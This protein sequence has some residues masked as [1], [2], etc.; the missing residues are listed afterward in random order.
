VREGKNSVQVGEN[1]CGKGKLRAKRKENVAVVEKICAER[2]EGRAGCKIVLHARWTGA[3]WRGHRSVASLTA[4]FHEENLMTGVNG[5]IST[6]VC[7][8]H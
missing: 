8:G 4:G 6:L 3:A 5:M 1:P 2:K 7:L